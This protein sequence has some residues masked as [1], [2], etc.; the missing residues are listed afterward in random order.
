MKIF[1]FLVSIFLLFTVGCSKSVKPYKDC[2]V[3]ATNII[4]TAQLEEIINGKEDSFVFDARSSKYDDGKRIPTAMSLTSEASTAEIAKKIPYKHSLVVTYCSNLQCP[5]SAR[6]AKR[7]H[8]LGY[9]NVKEYPE[10]IAGWIKAGKHVV[11]A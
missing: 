7:L 5:A 2:A 10:G 6:L 4:T 11:D 8:K 1:S 3:C 9:T